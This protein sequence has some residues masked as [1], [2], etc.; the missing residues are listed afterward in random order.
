LGARPMRAS[1][2]ARRGTGTAAVW[3]GSGRILA[4]R[5]GAGPQYLGADRPLPGEKGRAHSGWSRHARG[6]RANLARGFS[7]RRGAPRMR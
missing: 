3:H 6:G 4:V 1:S 2:I 5:G 7:F